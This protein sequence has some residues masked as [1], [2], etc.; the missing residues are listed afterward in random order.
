MRPVSKSF[1]ECQPVLDEVFARCVRGNN[2]AKVF[3]LVLAGLF[4]VAGA[5]FSVHNDENLRLPGMIGSLLCFLLTGGVGFYFIIKPPR[6]RFARIKARLRDHPE[7]LVWSYILEQR[8]NGIPTWFVVMNFRDKEEVHIHRRS[9]PNKDMEGF[10]LILSQLNP[11][12]HI[13]YSDELKKMYKR[14]EM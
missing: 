12:M 5:G 1:L 11:R 10:I 13:G 9:F 7:D 4:L 6:E 8:T 3:F 14:G 2:K